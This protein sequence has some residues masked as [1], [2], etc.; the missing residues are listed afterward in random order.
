M[1]PSTEAAPAPAQPPDA[2]PPLLHAPLVEGVV[3]LRTPRLPVVAT[4]TLVA[5]PGWWS[6]DL[7]RFLSGEGFAT[8]VDPSGE[9]AFDHRSLK[10]DAVI[11]DLRLASRSA[12]AICVAWRRRSA[13]PVL[14]VA[15]SRDE[16]TVLDAFAAGA[17]HVVMKDATSRQIVAHL[18]SLLRRMPPRRT[19][20]LA[21]SV[22]SP[23][24]LG[25]DGRSALVRGR[26][27]SLT[28]EE[29]QMLALLLDRAGRVVTRADLAGSIRY[30]SGNARAVDFFVR[31]LREKLE[32]VDTHRRIV[33]VRGVGFRFDLAG[34]S[35]GGPEEDGGGDR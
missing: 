24:H 9:S 32:L 21:P 20:A 28:A 26:V 11:I 8:V 17:D 25:D 22:L 29:F 14:A 27:V 34:E 5:D 2:P 3:D 6:D 35:V 7:I 4:I 15:G 1:T 33:V 16:K 18:R 12:I 31:R 19:S 30:A 10:S 23:V 13:A